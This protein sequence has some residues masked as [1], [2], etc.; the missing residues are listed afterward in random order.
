MVTAPNQIDQK[1]LEISLQEIQKNYTSDGGAAAGGT[2]GT[3]GTDVPGYPG[4]TGSGKSKSEEV[5]RTVN[6]EVNHINDEITY[7]PFVVKDLTINVG[8]EPPNK[9]DPNS[10]S[11]QTINEVNKLLV[12]IVRASLA[13]SRVTYTEAQL[14]QKVSVMATPF[15]GTAAAASSNTNSSWLLYGGLGALATALLAGGV[16]FWMRRK[17]KREEKR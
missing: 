13:D 2:P 12:N 14:A 17:H 5:S 16:F 11:P 10:L 6:Y 3:G 9:N 4:A 8:I 1:G 15:A 7:S